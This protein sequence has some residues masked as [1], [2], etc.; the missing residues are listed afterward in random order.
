MEGGGERREEV[1]GGVEERKGVADGAAG[2]AS[3]DTREQGKGC[4]PDGREPP[5]DLWTRACAREGRYLDRRVQGEG[6]I[7]S[8]GK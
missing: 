7:Q 1:E 3:R 8:Q 5:R 6:R 4:S 2:R